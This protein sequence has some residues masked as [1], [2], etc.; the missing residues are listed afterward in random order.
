MRFIFRISW[1]V[2]LV[3]TVIFLAGFVTTNHRQI[4]ILFWPINTT[5]TGEIWM[6]IL[7]AFGLGL[8][9][10]AVVF[11]LHSLRLRARLWSKERRINE[12]QTRIERTEQS[13]DD[14]NLPERY[15]QSV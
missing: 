2:F 1:I 14:N 4:E 8:I 6:F 7:G 10:G 5:A 3:I 13:D 9:A 11:W 15:G 12:L